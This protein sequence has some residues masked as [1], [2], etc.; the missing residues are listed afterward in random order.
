V[1]LQDRL[2]EIRA[3]GLELAAISYDSPAVLDAFAKRYGIDF[4]LLADPGSGVIKKFGLL[5]R[6][7]ESG[8]AVGVPYPGTFVLDPAGVVRQRFFEATYQE[9]D[10]ASAMLLAL[11]AGPAGASTRIDTPHLE[12]T[13]AVSDPTISPGHHFTIAFDVVPRPG[14]HVYA[15]GTHA[16]RPITP[17]FDPNAAL[18]LGDVHWP[19]SREYHFVPLDERVPVYDEPFRFLQPMS[20]KVDEGNALLKTSD[21]LVISGALSYQACDAKICHPPQQVPFRVS[22][23]LRPLIRDRQP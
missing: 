16:Y 12:A 8:P 11:G 21:T 18:A 5:N 15:R 23:G 20:L 17:V 13:I 14:M 10:A 4:P 3:R 6:E 19:A 2:P 22:V 1:Q 7:I 9:R